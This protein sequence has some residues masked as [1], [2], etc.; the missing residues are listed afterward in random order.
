MS[1]PNQPTRVKTFKMNVDSKYFGVLITTAF[2]EATEVEFPTFACIDAK[3]DYSEEILTAIESNL[4][5][6]DNLLQMIDSEP[7]D[8]EE[9]YDVYLNIEGLTEKSIEEEINK[10]LV[11][12]DLKARV[13]ETSE[14]YESDDLYDTL[15]MYEAYIEDENEDQVSE[16]T[17][18][19]CDMSSVR[20]ELIGF[21]KDVVKQT[22]QKRK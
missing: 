10:L 16:T 11:G 1:K 14:M 4:N 22:I 3:G 20:D 18:R 8:N 2:Y 5:K 13:I 9:A 12:T 19:Y 15:C 6:K 7:S 21:V 17:G